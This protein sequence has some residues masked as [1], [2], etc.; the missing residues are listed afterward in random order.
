MAVRFDSSSATLTI[1]TAPQVHDPY[2][3]F[4]LLRPI[5]FRI[6]TFVSDLSD[7]LNRLMAGNHVWFQSDWI[8][9]TGTVK[10]DGNPGDNAGNWELGFLQVRNVRTTWLHYKANWTDGGARNGGPM[11]LQVERPPAMTRQNCR[12]I[13]DRGPAT[14]IW[15]A[16]RL[17]ARGSAGAFPQTLTATF[18]D[19]PGTHFPAVLVNSL[20][21]QPNFLR[22][23]QVEL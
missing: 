4:Q 10:L 11:L 16:L 9:A 12:D 5:R 7:N 8:R 18:S 15:Y 6:G 2:I 14:Q 21:K 19:Q 13:G 23:G 3:A 1:G 17:N 22:E 20:T